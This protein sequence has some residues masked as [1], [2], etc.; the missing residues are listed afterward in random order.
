M[1]SDDCAKAVQ[2]QAN[3]SKKTILKDSA[4]L[5]NVSRFTDRIDSRRDTELAYSSSR[6]V[7]VYPQNDLAGQVEL[8]GHFCLRKVN[9]IPRDDRQR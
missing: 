4:S 8:N 9:A 6:S 7:D 5:M 2:L 1:E 3:Q